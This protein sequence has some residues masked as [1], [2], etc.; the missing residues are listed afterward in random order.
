EPLRPAD[1]GSGPRLAVR[2]AR[3]RGAPLAAAPRRR[4]VPGA[5]RLSRQN[6]GTAGG[7]GT[8]RLLAA[9]DPA[10]ARAVSRGPVRAPAPRR[11]RLR[12]VDEP[13]PR[14]PA[15]DPGHRGGAVRETPGGFDAAAGQ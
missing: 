2:R 6:P 12:A 15:G 13:A 8:V 1:A 10:A 11:A 9:P 14:L 3:R 7:G 5:V 4:A